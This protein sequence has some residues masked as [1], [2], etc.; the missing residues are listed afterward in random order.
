MRRSARAC[1]VASAVWSVA[2]A[3]GGRYRSRKRSS[4]LGSKE[5]KFSSDFRRHKAVG[6][7]FRNP[8]IIIL[9][10]FL[11]ICCLDVFLLDRV[12]G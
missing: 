8:K 1:D 2:G 10:L 4:R 6:M 3:A 12:E 9:H 7:I 11:D 5:L